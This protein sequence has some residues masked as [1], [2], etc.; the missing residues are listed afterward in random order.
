[1]P[2]L[3]RLYWKELQRFVA[4]FCFGRIRCLRINDNFLPSFGKLRIILDYQVSLCDRISVVSYHMLLPMYSAI[5][6]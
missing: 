6:P 2:L 1:M 3:F 5:L 4:L